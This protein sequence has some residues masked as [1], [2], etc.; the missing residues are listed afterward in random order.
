MRKIIVLSMMLLSGTAVVAQTGASCQPTSCGPNGTKKTEAAVIT[1]LRSEILAL[2]GDI[3]KKELKVK[4]E[5]ATEQEL[6]KASDGESLLVMASH[7]W[8]LHVALSNAIPTN[9]VDEDFQN[10]KFNLRSSGAQLVSD[11]AQN[12]RIM[13]KQVHSLIL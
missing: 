9:H 1:K 6:K 10:L 2:Q 13:K 3:Q 11:L 4:F 12:L 8:Q 7:L 5:M